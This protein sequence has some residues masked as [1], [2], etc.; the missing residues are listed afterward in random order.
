MKPLNASQTSI[1]LLHFVVDQLRCRLRLHGR[2]DAYCIPYDARAI[3]LAN[4]DCIL[5]FS[6]YAIAI[7]SRERAN[8]VGME[9]AHTNVTA[10]EHHTNQNNVRNVF[11]E[12]SGITYAEL[13]MAKNREIVV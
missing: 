12:Q 3:A 11:T 9:L 6:V 10:D 1:L 4:C 8:S 13:M 7:G 2:T 5:F